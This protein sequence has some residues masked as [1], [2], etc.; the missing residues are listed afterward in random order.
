[1]VDAAVVAVVVENVGAAF[2]VDVD[3][4]RASGFGEISVV[5][6]V[7]RQFLLIFSTAFDGYLEQM[8]SKI[9]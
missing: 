5:I 3:G 7:I 2:I 1:M 4:L 6:D 9:D 8:Q